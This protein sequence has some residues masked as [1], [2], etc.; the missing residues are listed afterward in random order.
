MTDKYQQ[1]EFWMEPLVGTALGLFWLLAY[2][3][4]SYPFRHM[5]LLPAEPRWY[6]AK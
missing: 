3:G 1:T 2:M 5:G 4:F 6:T